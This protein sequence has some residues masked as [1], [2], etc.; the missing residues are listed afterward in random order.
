[1][2][3]NFHQ[4]Q[5]NLEQEEGQL[6]IDVFQT[7]TDLVVQSTVAGV[8]MEDLE[9]LVHGDMLVIRGKRLPPDPARAEQYLYRECYWGPFARTIVLPRDVDPNRIKAGL[10]N[11]ILTVR[12]PRVSTESFKKVDVRFEN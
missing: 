12:I 5:V 10:K 7:D 8:T 3:Q 6:S 2:D 11:G 9:I 4:H 1:M